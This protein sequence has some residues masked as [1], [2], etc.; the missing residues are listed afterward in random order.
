MQTRAAAGANSIHRRNACRNRA[1]VHNPQ[2]CMT[3][4]GHKR[5]A[6]ARSQTTGEGKTLSGTLFAQSPE[7]SSQLRASGQ[8]LGRGDQSLLDGPAVICPLGTAHRARGTDT[9][10][11][12][13]TRQKGV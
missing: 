5:H 3:G 10:R 12:A 7:F 4:Q 6:K 2:K 13:I 9:F 8:Q 1:A 11:P